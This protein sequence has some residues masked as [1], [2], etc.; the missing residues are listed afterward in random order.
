VGDAGPDPGPEA[1]LRPLDLEHKPSLPI[2]WLAHLDLASEYWRRAA[3]GQQGLIPLA[4]REFA[5]ALERVPPTE[6]DHMALL[7]VAARYGK[8]ETVRVLYYVHDKD[9]EFSAAMLAR[10]TA[11]EKAQAAAREAPTRMRHAGDWLQFGQFVF[12]VSDILIWL[13]KRHLGRRGP[14]VVALVLMTL[15]LWLNWSFLLEMYRLWNAY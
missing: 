5:R 12:G 3:E 1:D 4:E 11:I 10:I 7:E 2:S 8:L 13:S 9:W 14:L 6:A 15:M